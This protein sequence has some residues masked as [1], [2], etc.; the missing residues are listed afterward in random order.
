MREGSEGKD[1]MLKRGRRREE[2]NRRRRRRRRRRDN[3]EEEVRGR[4]SEGNV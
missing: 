1:W 4:E 2:E 3:R